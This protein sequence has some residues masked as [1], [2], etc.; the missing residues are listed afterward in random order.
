MIDREL[1]D[2]LAECEAYT[3]ELREGIRLRLPQLIAAR[4]S[5][6][7]Y[8]NMIEKSPASLFFAAPQLPNGGFAS[9]IAAD[10]KECA[11]AVVRILKRR[12][13]AIVKAIEKGRS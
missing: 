6:V 7:A 10:E 4:D 8:I 11:S 1:D 2:V 5:C 13:A 9:L 12:L 3:A